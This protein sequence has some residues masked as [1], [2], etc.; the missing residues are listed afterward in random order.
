VVDDIRAVAPEEHWKQFENAWTTLLSYRY[1]G[2][3]SPDLAADVPCETM[4]LRRD[5]RNSSGGIMAAPLCV[6]SPEPYW[7]DTECIPAPVLMSYEILDSAR[8]VRQVEVIRDVIHLG[9][10]MGFSRSRIVDASDRARLIAISCG[11]GVSLGEVPEGYQKVDNPPVMVEDD[12][13][14]PSLPIAFGASRGDDGMWRLPKL[15]A[16]LSSPHAALHLGP[17]NIVLEAAA[18]ECATTRTGTDALQ[19]ES[20]TVMMVRPGVVGPFRATAD[21]IGGQSERIPMQLTLRDEGREDRVISTAMAVFRR[22]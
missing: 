5:M 11:V 18:M 14:L 15:R 1:L 3:R 10:T 13:S 9:R 19:V 12:D 16:E 8:D 20:W 2:K 6:A 22:V 17:I 4:P 7:L 21:A